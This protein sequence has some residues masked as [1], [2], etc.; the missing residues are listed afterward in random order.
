TQFNLVETDKPQE[1]ASDVY[2][3]QVP[4]PAGKGAKQ[5]VT[6]EHVINS[7]VQLT[8]LDDNNIRIFINSPVTSEK[9]KAGLQQTQ[10][11]RWAL[12]KTQQETRELERQLK[13]ITDDQARLRLNIKEMPTTAAAY[14]RYLEKFDLQET[15]IEKYQADIKKLQATEHSQ[16][17]E[18][19]D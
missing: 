6:E 18:F 1:T 12:A 4:V 13:T 2:R 19:E 17:K 14:K 10:Q 5:V 3:F 11:L 16:R 7:S 15:Q 8:N 9:V